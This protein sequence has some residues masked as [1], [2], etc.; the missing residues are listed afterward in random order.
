MSIKTK[1]LYVLYVAAVLLFAGTVRAEEVPFQQF[2]EVE[3]HSSVPVTDVAVDYQALNLLVAGH[4]PNPC[5]TTPSAQ[6]TQDTENPSTLIVRLSSPTPNSLCVS[7][8][9]PYK[10]IVN[11]PELARAAQLNLENKA[12]YLIKIVGY[13]F[14][15]QVAGSALQ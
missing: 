2:T 3:Y 9:K 4:L 8:I 7:Q 6:M 5:F 11:L 15:M 12:L 10:T 1:V 13:P 14:E